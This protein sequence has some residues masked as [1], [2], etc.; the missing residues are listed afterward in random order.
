MK[1]M[2]PEAGRMARTN[3]VVL[4]ADDVVQPGRM[5][6]PED[7]I[8]FLKAGGEIRYLPAPLIPPD[9]ALDRLAW[10]PADVVREDQ[11]LASVMDRLAER[12]VLAVTN[13]NA[14]IVGYVS[15]DDA[16]DCVFKAYKRLQAYFDTVLET[17][18]ASISAIDE[19]GRVVIWTTG[20]EQIFN[21]KKEEILGKPITD[22]FPKDMLKTLNSLNTGLSIYRGQHRP[23]P[24]KVVLINV[25]PVRLDERIIGAVACEVDITTQIQMHHQLQNMTSKIYHLEKEVAKHSPSRDPFIQIKGTSGALRQTIETIRKVSVTGATV[26]ILGES[27]VGKELFAKAIHDLRED[28]HSPFVPINCGAIPPTLFESELFGYEKGAFSGADQRGKIGKIELARGG[29]LFLDEIGELPLDMQ[30]KLL[31]VLQEKKYFPVGGTKMVDA[32]CRIIA[33]TN[34]D[35]REMVSQGKFREDLFYR[36][37]VVTVEI[38]PLR[39]R[40]E[41]IFELTH[42]FLYEFTL[43][44]NRHIQEF[45]QEVMQL[46]LEY[47]W[48]G[49][50]RELRNTIERLVIFT[51][52]GVIRTEYLPPQIRDLM[53][54]RHQQQDHE[55]PESR[56]NSEAAYHDE[57]SAFEKAMLQ[58]V[59]EQE[60]GNK[61]AVAKRLGISRTTLYNKL[62]RLG[63][64]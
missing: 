36:L 44:Y 38:P 55:S 9:S 4:T 6:F 1:N 62:N 27:G 17:T 29:T 5:P 8:V 37:N 19:A 60:N 58:K 31:R 20:A 50:V 48:P 22:F 59:L 46:L 21:Y 56:P 45:P 40:K 41:D 32:D 53:K 14:K 52:D 30:V 28:E 2:L 3:F 16:L 23:N 35:L 43:L 42:T 51:T 18:D 26:L 47:D 54:N 15:A 57:L 25:N 33:A 24:D 64:R 11:P 7:G 13:A 10:R 34:R 49:N 12:S 39:Q 61:A 63:I